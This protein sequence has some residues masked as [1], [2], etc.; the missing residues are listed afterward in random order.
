M[1]ERIDYA[2]LRD[3]LDRGAECEK[4]GERRA[5]DVL[6]HDVVRARLS[7]STE[8]LRARI[9][10]SPHGFAIV[11]AEDQTVLG[12]LRGSWPNRARRHPRRN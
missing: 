6:R 10:A 5:I 9:E 1:F 2:G 7:H 11:V 3:L 12:R 8:E 4:A